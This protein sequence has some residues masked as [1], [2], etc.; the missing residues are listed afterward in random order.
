MKGKAAQLPLVGSIVRGTLRIGEN[1]QGVFETFE[2]EKTQRKGL[3]ES[4]CPRPKKLG[5]FL[6]S[7]ADPDAC[8]AK[9]SEK[10]CESVLFSQKMFFSFF[11]FDF[12]RERPCENSQES[13]S[14]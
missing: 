1:G 3:I 5:F 14:S 7:F 6:V 8:T 9:S 11:L 13:W 2:V 4:L 12:S 10:L